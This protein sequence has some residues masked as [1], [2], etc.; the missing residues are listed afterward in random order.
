LASERVKGKRR[1]QLGGTCRALSQTGHLPASGEAPSNGAEGG[2][3][4]GAGTSAAAGRAVVM[5][6]T[7]GTPAEGSDTG[8]ARTEPK[9]DKADALPH[10]Q[11]INAQFVVEQCLRL[12]HRLGL[13]H[14]PPLPPQ[15]SDPDWD[16]MVG[17]FGPQVLA[18]SPSLGDEE[19]ETVDEDDESEEKGEE[20]EDEGEEGEGSKQAGAGPSRARSGG[21]TSPHSPDI[22]AEYHRAREARI[23]RNNAICQSLGLS[24]AAKFCGG[25]RQTGGAA[26]PG[27]A[28]GAAGGAEPS[29]ASLASA[30]DGDGATAEGT[31]AAVHLEVSTE[32]TTSAATP[33]DPADGNGGGV[34]GGTTATRSRREQ[35][36]RTCKD[37]AAP[38]GAGASGP[39][40]PGGSGKKGCGGSSKADA[41]KGVGSKGKKL[42]GRGGANDDEEQE[43][44][45]YGRVPKVRV[46][47]QPENAHLQ[48][49]CLCVVGRRHRAHSRVYSLKA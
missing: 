20:E 27:A 14:A 16:E 3:S 42:Q 4:T 37:A 38:S 19:E 41:R 48:P 45:D 24:A 34:G 12:V 32:A 46:F 23:A 1:G 21:W 28:S 9:L 29:P 36:K 7:A 26:Q 43:V 5:N 17:R 33:A 13:P 25:A 10:R 49:R 31:P 15:L 2:S 6:G 44:A 35:P 30:T 8:A 47:G 11:H 18:G 40:Q 22:G 39:S